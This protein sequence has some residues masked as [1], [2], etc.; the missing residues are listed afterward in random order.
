MPTPGLFDDYVKS[1]KGPVYMDCRGI[2][3]EDHEY[4]I[5]W[6]KQEGNCALVDH[7]QEEGIDLKKNPVEFMT[8][9]MSTRGGVSFNERG[10]TSLPG[11]YAGGDE[12]FRSRRCGL[13]LDLRRKCRRLCGKEKGPRTLPGERIRSNGTRRSSSPSGTDKQAPAGRR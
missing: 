10:E 3:R 8:Y 1:G 11:L 9:E 5:Y 12:Y 6:L 4:M 7:L 2:T 13:R